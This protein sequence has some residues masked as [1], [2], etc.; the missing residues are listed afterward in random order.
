M[1]DVKMVLRDTIVFGEEFETENPLTNNPSIGIGPGSSFMNALVKAGTIASH[2]LSF[3]DAGDKGEYRSP[4]P[5]DSL[6]PRMTDLNPV[7]TSLASGQTADYL[8]SRIGDAGK[9]CLHPAGG[10]KCYPAVES[11]SVLL[12]AVDTEK[13]EGDLIRMDLLKRQHVSSQIPIWNLTVPMYSVQIITPGEGS[14]G[15]EQVS[16]GT[17]IDSTPA[18]FTE[19]FGISYFPNATAWQILD[20]A[21]AASFYDYALDDADDGDMDADSRLQ[22]VPCSPERRKKGSVKLRF[23][24]ECGPEFEVPFDDFVVQ[25]DL[26]V[27]RDGMREGKPYFRSKEFPADPLG[28][29]TEKIPWC[30]FGVLPVGGVWSDESKEISLGYAIEK[31]LYIVYDFANMEVAVAR[32]KVGATKSNWVAF[33][34]EGAKIPRAVKLDPEAK[35]PECK[36]KE[37]AS[38]GTDVDENSGGMIWV[39]QGMVLGIGLAAGMA[40]L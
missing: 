17:D 12:G 19:N 29:G 27:P 24:G 23:G 2:A 16:T 22:R 13:Y 36:P 3:Y 28:N 38:G 34:K 26:W 1:K 10:D 31:H 37:E 35:G 5:H 25:E 32:K 9:E 20:A 14:N 15:K 39:N 40:V 4:T 11:G 30:V 18:A 33:E 7:I 21:G 8:R 6:W